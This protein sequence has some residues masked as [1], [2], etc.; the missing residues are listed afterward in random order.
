MANAPK[1]AGKEAKETLGWFYSHRF[2]LLRRL[3]Q[4]IVLLM[5]ISGP[6]YGIWILRGNYSSSRFLDTIPATDPFI[7]LQSLMTGHWPTASTVLIGVVIIT[8]VYALFGGRLYCSWVCPFNP[9]T[10]LASW[11]RRKL[12]IQAG[13]TIS[14]KLRYAVLVGVLLGSFA[15]GVLIWE[16]VNPVSITGRGIITAAAEFAKADKLT[17]STFSQILAFAFGAGAWMLL[18]V[19]I[20]DLLVV[21]NGWCGH[22]C[23]MGA[24]YAVIGYKGILHVDAKKRDA[25]T[26]CMDC[27]NVCP[28][29]QVLPKPLF[30]KQKTTLIGSSECTRCGR[31]IDVCPEKVFVIKVV[32]S[33]NAPE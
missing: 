11:C 20:F 12:G 9:V 4:L 26:N 31:C 6:L 8:L 29:P 30:G 27:I 28:E 22:L 2:L 1:I 16:W 25:C 15:T 21:K 24:L 23:P 14:N 32:P 17:Y 33:K 10:D 5:F 18:A 19:F 13:L 3:T 7:F